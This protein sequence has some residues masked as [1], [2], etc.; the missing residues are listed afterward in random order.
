MEFWELGWRILDREIFNMQYAA[1]RRDIIERE[2]QNLNDRQREAVFHTEG[3]LLVLA[4]AGSGKT[5]VLINR[6][7]NIIRFGSGAQSETAPEGAGEDELRELVEYLDAPRE[8]ARERI[9]ELCAVAPCRPWQIL[10]ITFTNKAANEL[11]ERL[12][13]AIGPEARDIWASTFHS[14]C[15]RILRRDIDK[16]GFSR[17]FTIYGDDVHLNVL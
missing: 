14:A 1:V 4:G 10:A 8:D 17:S 5:T 11:K 2:F 9:T 6:I 13:R 12:E 16:L 15:V 3:P 7:A